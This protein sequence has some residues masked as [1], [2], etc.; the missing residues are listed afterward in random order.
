MGFGWR[1]VS[2]LYAVMRERGEGNKRLGLRRLAL[3]SFPLHSAPDWTGDADTPSNLAYVTGVIT[4]QLLDTLASINHCREPCT[5]K[6]VERADKHLAY[7]WEHFDQW[8]HKR[9]G[10]T[11]GKNRQYALTSR[12]VILAPT[13]LYTNSQDIQFKKFVAKWSVSI[14]I[15]FRANG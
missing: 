2:W 11:G 12:C 4:D 15:Y 13:K 8:N 9:E 10:A 7:I 5:W 14:L 3:Y 6:E 1:R